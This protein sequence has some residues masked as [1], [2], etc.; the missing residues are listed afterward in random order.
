MLNSFIAVLD[1]GIGGISLLKSLTDALPEKRFLYF[2][3]NFNAPYG[4]KPLSQL[5]QITMR[6]IDFLMQY[7][8]EALVLGCNTLSVNLIDEIFSYS[9]IPVFGVFPP[10]E[11]A[12]MSGEKV[13]LLST[14]LTAKKYSNQ[15]GVDVL[16]FV[17]LAE[18][19]EKNAFCLDEINVEK[20][21]KNAYG[22][23]VDKKGYYDTLILG[24]THYFFIKN[25]ILDHFCPR[26]ILSGNDFTVKCVKKYFQNNK[27][28]VNHLRNQILFVG[29]NAKYNE[30]FLKLSGYKGLKM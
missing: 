10:V 22:N 16:G 8:L 24:C 12:C 2:G 23:F 11:S 28:L 7:N 19:I 17:N 27:K 3:D 21:I 18:D 29:D 13:L 30:K 1:S 20:N 25:K 6:N 4:N 15:N 14:C 26:K 9:A 5:R